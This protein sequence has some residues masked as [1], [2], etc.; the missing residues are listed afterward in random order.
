MKYFIPTL[1]VLLLCG[2]ELHAQPYIDTIG[3]ENPV[4]PDSNMDYTQ[5]IDTGNYMFMVD[6]GYALDYPNAPG[7]YFFGRKNADS[8]YDGFTYSNVVDS[9]DTGFLGQRAAY[10]GS[11]VDASKQYAV[12]HGISSGIFL[13]LVYPVKPTKPTKPTEPTVAYGFYIT[14]ATETVLRLEN[15]DSTVKKFG[16]LDGTDPDWLLLTIKG[17]QY[18]N[19]LDSVQFYLADFRD[20]DTTQ[21]YIIKDWRYVDISSLGYVDSISF[22]LSSSDTDS[23]GNMNTP[24]YFCMDNLSVTFLGGGAVNEVEKQLLNANIY[25]NPAHDVLHITADVPVNADVM[26]ASG[27]VICANKKA[28]SITVGSL[29]AGFYFVKLT[30]IKT[31][32]YKMLKFEKLK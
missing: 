23:V 26:D 16:G 5:T 8:S 19:L 29:A 27:K 9:T 1:F 13:N 11:G 25:P 20:S 12:V 21:H 31:G 30:D 17:Y 7:V 22:S 4:L 14:N 15:G 2:N 28:K 24:A 3:F 32:G 6:G 18:G 10:P